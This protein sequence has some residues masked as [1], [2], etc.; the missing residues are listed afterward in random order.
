MYS[1]SL[2]RVLVGLLAYHKQHALYRSSFDP[3]SS[4]AL[5]PSWLFQVLKVF[6]IV[7]MLHRVCHCLRNHGLTFQ[8]AS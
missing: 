8:N 6:R 4:R 1:L 5:K 3:R 7:E 2:I